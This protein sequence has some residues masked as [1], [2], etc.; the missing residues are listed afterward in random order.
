MIKFNKPNR[1]GTNRYNG[2]YNVLVINHIRTSK[3]GNKFVSRS[4]PVDS[5]EIYDNYFNFVA[6]LVDNLEYGKY[7]PDTTKPWCNCKVNP[8]TGV[9]LDVDRDLLTDF[10]TKEGTYSVYVEATG[11]N[12]TKADEKGYSTIWIKPEYIVNITKLKK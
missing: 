5:I 4:I 3:N 9:N 2:F 6:K 10:M 7:L 12:S 8:L 11:Y 1:T